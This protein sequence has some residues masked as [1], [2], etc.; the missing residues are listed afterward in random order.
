ML[1][2]AIRFLTGPPLPPIKTQIY[3]INPNNIKWFL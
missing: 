2:K 3:K 1:S